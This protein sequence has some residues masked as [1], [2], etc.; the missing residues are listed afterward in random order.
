MQSASSNKNYACRP[1]DSMACAN[2][3]FNN[4]AVMAL[5]KIE[6]DAH[7]SVIPDNGIHLNYIA[8][9]WVYPGF[10]PVVSSTHGSYTLKT[11]PFPRFTS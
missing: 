3:I 5:Q 10:L 2:K 9:L 6:D 1:E 8:R 4:E 7:R 11:P